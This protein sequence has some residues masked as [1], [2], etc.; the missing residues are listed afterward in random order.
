MAEL[1]DYSGEITFAE[2]VAG[3]GQT[4]LAAVG[5]AKHIRRQSG[6]LLEVL[7]LLAH[8]PQSSVELAAKMRLNVVEVDG[9]IDVL[10]VLG[11][12]DEHSGITPPGRAELSAG[13][14]AVR[15]VTAFLSGSS[16]PYYPVSL[17]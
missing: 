13:K 1:G 14:S 11:L 9:L 3:A 12:V 8:G 5:P 6:R 4:R 15:Q 2:V 16:E 10:R 17:R 7:A